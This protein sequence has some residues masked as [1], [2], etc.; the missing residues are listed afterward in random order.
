MKTITIENFI[1]KLEDVFDTIDKGSLKPG[2]KF[3]D[4]ADW[5]S[6]NAMVLVAL[7]ETEFERPI[8]FDQLRQ[9]ETVNDLY[10]L[11]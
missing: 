1:L 6:L 3:R 11:I 7:F 10:D 5:T 9:C 2:V 8:T 4:L